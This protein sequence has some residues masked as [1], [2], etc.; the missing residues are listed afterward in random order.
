[1]WQKVLTWLLN[2]ITIV[3]IV[4]V[5]LLAS[6]NHLNYKNKNLTEKI[7]TQEQVI[8]T[9]DKSIE[10][11]GKDAK[12]ISELSNKKVQIYIKQQKLSDQL[13]E[14]PDTSENKPFTNPELFDAARVLR[15]YQNSVHTVNPSDS[16]K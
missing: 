3:S 5:L 11:L 8:D 12:A 4:I 2:P 6:V 15:D 13:N 1:M 16:N 7:T 10:I 9:Q 14:I